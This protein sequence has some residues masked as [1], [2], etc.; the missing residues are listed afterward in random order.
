MKAGTA[1]T[2]VNG[3]FAKVVSHSIKKPRSSWRKD[4]GQTLIEVALLLPLLLLLLVGTIEI[5]RFAY[6]AILVANSA[7]AGAQ[8]GSQSLV[9]SADTAGITTAAKNDGQS[10]A[11]LGVTVHQ[12]CGCVGSS[13]STTCPATACT[14]PNHALVYVQVH[15]SGTFNSIFH[16]PGLPTSLALSSTDVMRVAQ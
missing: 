12:E 7:R 1:M 15:V 10:I 16:Y 8:Y 5:G 4:S 3:P 9:T 2:R 6:Y 11:A 13:I 14:Y